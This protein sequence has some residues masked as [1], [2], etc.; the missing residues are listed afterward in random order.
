MKTTDTTL[1]DSLCLKIEQGG[2]GYI[3][4]GDTILLNNNRSSG[5]DTIRVGKYESYN[6]YDAE[7]LADCL[8]DTNILLIEERFRKCIDDLKG[9][10]YA[11]A[12]HQ[13]PD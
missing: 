12:I 3:A 13:L 4:F 1:V 10:Y 8:C 5:I 7:E 2:C 9:I 11:T 6:M